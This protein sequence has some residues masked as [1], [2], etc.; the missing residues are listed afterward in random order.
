MW[1]SIWND[2]WDVILPTLI[3]SIVIVGIGG[4]IFY[5]LDRKHVDYRKTIK[6][7]DKVTFASE[8]FFE[9]EVIADHGEKVEVIVK[10]HKNQIYKPKEIKK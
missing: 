5:F 8:G 2:S 6:V 3:M 1:N 10:V 7:G 9:G 4:I